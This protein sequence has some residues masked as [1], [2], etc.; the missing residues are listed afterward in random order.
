VKGFEKYWI[1]KEAKRD[2][3]EER[4]QEVWDTIGH[5]VNVFI[6]GV[7]AFFVAIG[8]IA[9]LGVGIF[10]STAKLCSKTAPFQCVGLPDGVLMLIFVSGA[11]ILSTSFPFVYGAFKEVEVMDEI[12]KKKN[13]EKRIGVKRK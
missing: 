10:F 11:M 2:Y 1:S 6:N 8:G 4:K 5:A 12:A 7:Y 3:Q 9:L 13:Q